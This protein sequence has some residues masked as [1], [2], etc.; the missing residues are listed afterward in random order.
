MFVTDCDAKIVK[1]SC[2]SVSRENVLYDERFVGR[3]THQINTVMK[4]LMQSDKISTSKTLKHLVTE[5]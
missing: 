5:N 3:T 4:T 1:F 2:A